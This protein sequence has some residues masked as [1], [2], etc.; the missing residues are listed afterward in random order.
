[1]D[2]YEAQ[3]P[4]NNEFNC[5]IINWYDGTNPA[6]GFGFKEAARL[7]PAGCGNSQQ[8]TVVNRTETAAAQ[9]V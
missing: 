8:S 1:L 3:G 7:T 4:A 6:T 9:N 5:G 2:T